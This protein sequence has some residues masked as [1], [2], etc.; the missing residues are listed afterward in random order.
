MPFISLSSLDVYGARLGFFIQGNP[1]EEEMLSTVGLLIK[2]TCFYKKYSISV[3]SSIS[4]LVSTRS[5]T[6]LILP[7]Q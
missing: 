5:S 2:I 6:V 4:E 7:L 1:T 3:K